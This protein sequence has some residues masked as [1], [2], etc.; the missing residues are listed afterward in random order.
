M[1][2]PFFDNFG[3]NYAVVASGDGYEQAGFFLVTLIPDVPD[4]VDLML[5]GKAATFNFRNSN[6]EH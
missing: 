1:S 6:S 5:L 2:L 3:D 4:V